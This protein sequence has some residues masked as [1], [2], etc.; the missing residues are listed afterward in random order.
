MCWPCHGGRM[1][2]AID[3]TLP[4]LHPGQERM[5]AALD[6]GRFVLAMCGRRTGKTAFGVERACRLALDGKR[7]GWFAPTYK[8]ADDAWREI[9]HRIR[10]ACRTVS[11]QQKRLETLSGGVVEMWT[12]DTPDPGRGRKYHLVVIDEAGLVRGLDGIWQAAIRPTLTDYAGKALFLGTPKGR[13]H[14]FSTLFARGEVEQDRWRSVRIGTQENPHIPAS[15]V[16][17][18]RRDLLPAIFA[19]EYE[20]IPADDGGN[21]FGISA[22]AEC[23]VDTMPNPDHPEHMPVVWGWDLAR[24]QD[25]TVGIALDVM[26]N[27]VRVER[28]QLVPWSETIRRIHQMTGDTPAWG[29]ATGVGDPI[30][31][32]LQQNGVGIVGYHFSGKSKQTLME[33]LA[34]A[35]QHQELHFPRGVI[36]AELESFGYEY[37]A[38][39]VRYEGADG[40]HDDAVMSL[41][42]ALY[43]YDQVR[44][45]MEAIKLPPRLTGDTNRLDDYIGEDGQA[46]QWDG[47]AA[48]LP[49]NW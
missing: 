42:L 25:W 34:S 23:T 2:K 30:I 43:G 1:A 13:S 20:G 26:G 6:A 40:M 10:P 4:R 12:L 31:E 14:D 37:T 49:V 38:H 44:P 35:I 7:V 18:A 5:K 21:P 46:G 29:D 28:W 45:M 8:Y 48:Q 41:A 17:E 15:E 27:V 9:V 33:R 11:E 47:F 3:I 19:Q 32:R 36:T 16:E 39:G 22:I 24:A